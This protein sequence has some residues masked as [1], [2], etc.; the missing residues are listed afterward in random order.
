[1]KRIDPHLETGML[2]IG[3]AILIGAGWLFGR[4]H[5]P[6]QLGL[7]SVFS[8]V[9]IRHLLWWRKGKNVKNSK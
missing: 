4:V 5:E 6:I 8:V 3:A 2:L 9:G 7:A 1:M